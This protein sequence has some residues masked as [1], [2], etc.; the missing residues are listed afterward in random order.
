V[1]SR[2]LYTLSYMGHDISTRRWLYP[3]KDNIVHKEKIVQGKK[4]APTPKQSPVTTKD[5]PSGIG[6]S[7]AFEAPPKNVDPVITETDTPFRFSI[8]MFHKRH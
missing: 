8:K 3:K 7:L 4:P 1:A 6:S 5:N 2:L